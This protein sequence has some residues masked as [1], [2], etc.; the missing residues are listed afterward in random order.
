MPQIGRPGRASDEHVVLVTELF[1]PDTGGSAVLFGNVY[2][3]LGERGVT[4]I[5][6]NASAEWGVTSVASVRRHVQTTRR[7]LAEC[8]LQRAVIH[9]GRALPEGLAALCASRLSGARYLCWAHGEELRYA[10]SSRELTFLLQR[11]LRGAAAILANSH[12]TARELEALDV[13]QEKVHVVHPGVDAARFEQSQRAC[14]IRRQYVR[15]GELLLLTLGRLQARK[16]Q[17]LT[18]EA[19]AA[20]G[21][22]GARIHYLIVGEGDDRARLEHLVAEHGLGDRVHFTG[23]VPSATLPDYYAAADI[24]VH[25]NRVDGAD[26]EGFGIVFLEA[27]AAG[28]PTIGGATG[29]VPEAIQDGT[30]GM[31]VTGTDADELAAAIGRFA[32]SAALRRR[33]GQAGRARVREHFTWERAATQVA[34]VHRRLAAV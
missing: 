1:P 9:C 20:M 24:F 32:A 22:A 25:P 30:T 34:A 5:R 7:L 29:G 26:F 4:V 3:R 19:L 28:L 15:P 8:R 18:I 6:P 21:V 2:P 11:V 10:R 27:A 33:M 12:N 14:E 13:P 23:A 31:L 17:D 16:G